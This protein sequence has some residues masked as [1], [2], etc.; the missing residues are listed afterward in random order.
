MPTQTE[1]LQAHTSHLLD[2]FIALRQRYSMLHPMLFDK[3]VIEEYGSG[4]RARGFHTLRHSL[5]LSCAQDMAKLSLDKDERTPSIKKLQASLQQETL[6]HELREAFAIWVLPNVEEETDP[7]IREALQRMEQR[8]QSERRQQFDEILARTQAAWGVL[9]ADQAL[10]GFQTV[11]DK[12]SAHTEVHLVADKYQFVDISTL[13][14]K[15]GDLKR[16]MDAMQSIVE[17]L[18][19]LIRNAGFAWE[20]LDAQLSKASQAFWVTSAA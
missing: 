5:F 4:A 1:K 11:R 6:R 13:G 12:V 18:G 16:F 15:W 2:A 19:L 8:E 14:I 17:D 9:Q 20:R 10:L 7:E 3:G